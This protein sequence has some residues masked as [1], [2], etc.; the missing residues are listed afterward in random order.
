[1]TF[2]NN[3]TAQ[4]RSLVKYLSIGLVVAGLISSPVFAAELTAAQIMQKVDDR[5]TGET[6][7]S[8]SAL[9]LIDKKKRQRIRQLKLFSKEY[10]Q[11]DKSVSFFMS[12][13]DVKDTAYMS[14]DWDDDAKEDDSW[15]YLP[16]L[17]K[18]NRIAASD[19]SGAFMGSDFSY[20]DIDGVDVEDFTYRL[21]KESEEV[22]GHD[23]WVIES[24]PKS[25]AIIK[26][27]GYLK[28]TSWIRKDIYMQVKAIINVKKGKRV[29][30]FQAK[31]IEQIQG[32][33][34]AKT[35]QMVTTKRNKL[36]HSS[37]LKINSVDYQTKVDDKMFENTRL[38]RGL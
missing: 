3:K 23:C 21:V 18:T 15:L 2:L 8:E 34:T 26:E 37:V 9:I 25:K 6:L 35:L 28:S 7:V 17:Q 38:Q 20:A 31:D 29:K 4:T 11:V 16:A 19:K 36:E 27:T 14:F 30:Y 24:I 10:D 33:W 1:M 32:I 13:A 5:D 12:P 22:N